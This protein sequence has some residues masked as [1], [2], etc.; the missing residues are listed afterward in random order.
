[1]DGRHCAGVLIPVLIFAIRVPSANAQAEYPIMEK[2]AKNVISQYQ[3][4]SCDSLMAKKMQ[5]P[6]AEKEQMNQKVVQELRDDPKM[7]KQFLDKVSG[8]IANRLF[9]CGLIP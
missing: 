2:V 3:N 9:E 5:P 8:P 4:S 7:R 1:M 6:S